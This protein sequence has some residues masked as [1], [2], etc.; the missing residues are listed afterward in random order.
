MQYIGRMDVL[1][2]SQYLVHKITDMVCAQLLGL[3]QFMKV[4]LHQSLYHVPNTMSR[5]PFTG[6]RQEAAPYGRQILTH[7]QQYK[8]LNDLIMRIHILE[9]LIGGRGQ[10]VYYIYDLPE[11]ELDIR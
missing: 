10:D 6:L 3:E 1:E 8:T 2:S 4:S 11:K 5:T 9:F 7:S